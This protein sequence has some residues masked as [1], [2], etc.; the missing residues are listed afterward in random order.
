MRVLENKGK[1]VL[2]MTNNAQP[3]CP[4]AVLTD[5]LV[6]LRDDYK[7]SMR[8]GKGIGKKITLLGCGPSRQ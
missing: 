1:M 4:R 5:R 6:V 3:A 7:G 2:V 8:L